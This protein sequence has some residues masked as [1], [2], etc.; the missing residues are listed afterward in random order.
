MAAGMVLG[1]FS[2][3]DTG[4]GMAATWLTVT[5]LGMGLV[6]PASMTAAM[7]ALSAERAGVGSALLVTIRLV[8]GAFGAAVLGSLLSAGYRG[9]VDVTG[10]PPAAAAAARDRVG[11]GLEIARQS[12]DAGA[13]AIDALGVHA[14]HGP[15][16][17][18][19]RGRHARRRTARG[20]PSAAAACGGGHR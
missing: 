11:G 8:G 10:L 4:Y 5:G 15:H 2:T 20:G 6:L 1:A 19:G 7:G 13:A 9:R 3:V 17:R 12:H 14:R 16:A 18:R